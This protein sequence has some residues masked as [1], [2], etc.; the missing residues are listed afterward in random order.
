MKQLLFAAAVFLVAGG[1]QA[2]SK[3][4]ITSNGMPEKWSGGMSL[5]LDPSLETLGPGATDAIRT[6]L[7]TW[8]TEVAHLPNVTFEIGSSPGTAALDGKNLVLAGPVTTPGKE[9]AL[10]LTTTYAD[11]MTGNII[12]ADIVFNTDYAFGDVA[13]LGSGCVSTWDLQA[14][15]T[16]EAGHFFGLDEDYTDVA[17][18]MY[19]NTAPCDVHKDVLTT[20]DTTALSTLYTPPTD[21]VAHC[22]SAPGGRADA[23][24]GAAFVALA[25]VSRRRRRGRRPC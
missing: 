9:D 17:A 10:A 7:G 6:A 15:A 16:H 1:A 14:V 12:E 3:P 23:T 18:T 8:L 13:N 25:V 24:W 20:E 11:T 19:V 22:S 5:V 4:R 2:A 21:V